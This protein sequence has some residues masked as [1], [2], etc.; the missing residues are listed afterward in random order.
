[1]DPAAKESNIPG[2][3]IGFRSITALRETDRWS[4]LQV[5]EVHLWGVSLTVEEMESRDFAAWLSGDE[6][7]RA[8]RLISTVHRQRFVAAHGAVR[9]ILSRYCGTRPEHLVFAST[10][11][12]KPF[13]RDIG[14]GCEALQFN[15]THSQGRALIAVARDRDIGV[16]LETLRRK[17]DAARLAN[18]FFSSRD[19]EYILGGSP[20]ERDERFL[21]VWVAKEAVSKARGSGITFPLNRDH[22][23]IDSE[24]IHGRLM[25][26]D[27]PMKP[28]V[29]R[30]VPLERQ[31][32]GAVAAE[33]HDWRLVLRT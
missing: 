13:L 20:S 8:A 7:A 19:Q 16:D 17:T 10:A 26:T 5:E 1:M 14:T 12:G 23:D 22:V 21:R 28:M 15:L 6:L 31:W 24:G 3:V 25:G 2:H 30:F 9:L 4:P 27:P 32:V 33:G 18:R 29:F 11:R